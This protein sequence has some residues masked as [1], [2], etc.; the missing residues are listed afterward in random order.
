MSINKSKD[1]PEPDQRPISQQIRPFDEL[2]ENIQQLAVKPLARALVEVHEH[3][4]NSLFKL[5]EKARN[6]NEQ[7]LNF[8]AMRKIRLN[9]EAAE[10][11]FKQSMELIFAGFPDK[12]Y[13]SFK[14]LANESEQPFEPALFS[15]DLS[16]VENDELEENIALENMVSKARIQCKDLLY[17]LNSRLD[18][19]VQDVQVD[20]SN[21]PLDPAQIAEAFMLASTGLD[22]DIKT[23]LLL[24]KQVDLI[25]MGELESVLKEVNKF[26]I[27]EGVLPSLRRKIRKSKSSSSSEVSP[28][29]VNCSIDD[30]LSNFEKD[31]PDNRLS[32]GVFEALS[33]LLKAKRSDDDFQFSHSSSS[34]PV[35][36]ENVLLDILNILQIEQLG[37]GF[38]HQQFNSNDPTGS[39]AFLHPTELGVALIESLSKNSDGESRRLGQHNEDVINL[40][41]M[42]FEFILDDYNLPATV[43]ALLARL[44]IPILKV[45]LLD[46]SFFDQHDHPARKLL[47]ELA[48]ACIGLSETDLLEQDDIFEQVSIVVRRILNEQSVEISL[49]Q[50]LY[51]EFEIYM[52]KKNHRSTIMEQRTLEKVYGQVKSEQVKDLIKE[53]LKERLG[54]KELPH[55]VSDILLGGWSRVLYT[56]YLSYGMPSPE[57]EKALVLVDELIFSV[58]INLDNK[59]AYE[60]RLKLLPDLIK[61]LYEGLE[62]VGVNPFEI[63][64]QLSAL[65]RAHVESFK[66]EFKYFQNI[67]ENQVDQIKL[68]ENRIGAMVKEARMEQKYLY[69]DNGDELPA[70]NDEVLEA[71]GQAEDLKSKSLFDEMVKNEIKDAKGEGTEKSAIEIQKEFL[72]KQ[73]PYMEQL[74]SVELGTWF[75]IKL[76]EVGKI[77]CKLAKKLEDVDLLV[78][79]GRFGNKI[80]ERSPRAFLDDMSKGL[81]KQL[82]SG[83]LFDR[84]IGKIFNRLGSNNKEIVFNDE[85]QAQKAR[86]KPKVSSDSVQASEEIEELLSSLADD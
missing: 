62:S 48:V 3:I 57:W 45:A 19:L 55:V 2:I 71:L 56:A 6:N 17:H 8:D 4:D 25:V 86:R 76:P 78:F 80:L 10:A 47:N 1:R 60:K 24:Y 5:A 27:K 42:L 20:E 64:A 85:G 81:V 30:N 46:P 54:N 61:G 14:T 59:D 70:I 28:D 68:I 13:Q 73:K 34:L 58:Q 15:E 33:G 9:R 51:D 67:N 11:S 69:S 50:E 65:E 79:V 23:K 29:P 16:L 12:H 63:S 40:V 39:D 26:L 49:F 77:R 32:E 41:S 74:D 53:I 75:E 22:L 35:V 83:F 84:A 72:K 82:D 7:A 18:T 44:Q 66:A 43:Q 37:S 31:F 38:D 52:N 21:N 36:E